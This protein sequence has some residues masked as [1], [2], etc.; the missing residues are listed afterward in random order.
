MS[1]GGWN[2]QYVLWSTT[3]SVS[4]RG[5]VTVV[6]ASVAVTTDAVDVVVV[7]VG[8]GR[9]VTVGLEPVVVV[10]TRRVELVLFA[11]VD[12]VLDGSLLG[13]AV[14]EL[15]ELVTFGAADPHAVNAPT[16]TSSTNHWRGL[17]R[18]CSNRTPMD[19]LLHAYR[20][21]VGWDSLMS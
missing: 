6:S 13:T 3:R 9:V 2:I 7:M 17:R 10:C 16:P 18:T 21:L 4:P 19:R 11:T 15:R 8:L 5:T 20:A 14:V 12:T 1:A